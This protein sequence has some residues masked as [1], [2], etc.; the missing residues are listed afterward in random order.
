VKELKYWDRGREGG[1]DIWRRGSRKD[2][3]FREKIFGV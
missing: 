2:V 3:D 1:G